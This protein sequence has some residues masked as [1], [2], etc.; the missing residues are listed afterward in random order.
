[1]RHADD[2]VTLDQLE[3]RLPAPLEQGT[4]FLVRRCTELM[5]KDIDDHTTEDLRIMLGQQLGVR[6]LL[7]LAV[8]LLLENPLASGDFYPGDLLVV[9]VRLPPEAWDPVPAR[10][11]ALDTRLSQMAAPDDPH[12]RSALDRFMRGR[13]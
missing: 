7:P 8:D 9:V 2:V 6:H 3:G 4:T 11:H 1:V 5:A 12:V 10:R 13:H